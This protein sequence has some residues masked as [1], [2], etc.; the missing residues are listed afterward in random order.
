M[1]DIVAIITQVQHPVL[2]G[3]LHYL[4][5]ENG[6]SVVIADTDIDGLEKTLNLIKETTGEGLATQVD[7]TSE[8]QVRNMIR[9]NSLLQFQVVRP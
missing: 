3:L 9:E 1:R 7:V 8:S 5:A 4:F 6:A 2:A